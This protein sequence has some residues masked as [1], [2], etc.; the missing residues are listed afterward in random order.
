M[1]APERLAVL[2]PSLWEA[3]HLGVGVGT[4]P[5]ADSRTSSVTTGL[6]ASL[7]A[8]ASPPTEPVWIEPWRQSDA[9]GH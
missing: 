6:A 2:C 9:R 3:L 4:R 8:A 5:P 7:P 1:I